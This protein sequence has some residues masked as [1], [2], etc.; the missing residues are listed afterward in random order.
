MVLEIKTPEHATWSGLLHL[1]PTFTSY[2]LSFAVVGVYWNNHHHL[3][4]SLKK[5]SSSIMWANLN[6]LFWLSLIPFGTKWMG[7]THF[8]RF[9]VIVYAV[10]LILCAISFNILQNRIAAHLVDGH[11]ALPAAIKKQNV[12][13]LITVSSVLLAIPAAFIDTRISLALFA[14]STLIWIVPSKV[15]E[16]EFL[17]EK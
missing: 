13:V 11:E 8:E 5:V 6:L 4:H 1:V 16:K 3:L 12:K 14:V 2:V 9:T 15:I 7:E 17:K 10:L